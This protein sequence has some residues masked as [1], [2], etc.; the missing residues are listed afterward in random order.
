[1]FRG[2]ALLDSSGKAFLAKDQKNALK[3]RSCSDR[4][5]MHKRRLP[6]EEPSEISPP[7]P[8]GGLRGSHGT[9]GWMEISNWLVVEPTHLRKYE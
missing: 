8:A 7:T 1:M 6:L 5:E 3:P 2:V 4:P 9:G